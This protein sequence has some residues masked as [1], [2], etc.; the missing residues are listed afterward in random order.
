MK[1]QACQGSAKVHILVIEKWSASPNRTHQVTLSEKT[2]I[3]DCSSI[4]DETSLWGKFFSF[5][6]YWTIYRHCKVCY[7]RR[8]EESPYEH[9]LCSCSNVCQTDSVSC[10]ELYMEKVITKSKTQNDVNRKLVLPGARTGSPR[11]KN[12]FSQGQETQILE[13]F[14]GEVGFM[15]SHQDCW[16]VVCLKILAQ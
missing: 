8:G 16:K 14:M 11:G 12:W 15:V 3:K 4:D 10:R 7:Q 2:W 9:L 1:F 5:F 13:R 6:F